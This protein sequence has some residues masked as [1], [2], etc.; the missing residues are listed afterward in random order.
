MDEQTFIFFD[1]HSGEILA[2]HIQV[3]AEGQGV[4]VDLD[5]LRRSYRAFPG[6]EIDP[7]GID[8]LDVNLELLKRSTSNQR[9]VVDLDT[10][11]LVRRDEGS[12]AS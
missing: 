6:Q 8:V 1:N 4:S 10:R 12:D 7:S 9:F 11:T 5:E 3:S 2:T